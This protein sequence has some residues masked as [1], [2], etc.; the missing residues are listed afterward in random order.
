MALAVLVDDRVR[1]GEFELGSLL[2]SIEATVDRKERISLVPDANDSF[3]CDA[4]GG[5]FQGNKG[6]HDPSL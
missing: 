1:S 6:G 3:S 2:S 5:K 4:T